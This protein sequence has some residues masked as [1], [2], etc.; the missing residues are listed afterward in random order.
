MTGRKSGNRQRTHASFPLTFLQ[1]V[2]KIFL[3][4]LNK[5]YL[6][7]KVKRIKK[8]I[9][10]R[11]EAAKYPFV[12]KE[13]SLARNMLGLSGVYVITGSCLVSG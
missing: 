8:K 10:A 12:F 1:V 6:P 9:K 5:R 7:K 3:M 2:R 4:R 13:K 11:A